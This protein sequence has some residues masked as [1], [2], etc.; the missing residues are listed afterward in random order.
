M[1]RQKSWR[2]ASAAHARTFRHSRTQE[3]TASEPIRKQSENHSNDSEALD[4]SNWDGT[5]NHYPSDWEM[6]D[7]D[8]DA[9]DELDSDLEELTGIELIS[10][11]AQAA[12]HEM[13]LLKEPTQETTGYKKIITVGQ[14]FGPKEWRK[15]ERK[16]GFGYTGNSERTRRR[17]EQKLRDK[18]VEDA[19]LRKR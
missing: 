13:D 15:A 17:N 2:K 5:V 18:E 11:L 3:P 6:T 9:A 14:T 19:K 12:Q 10:S 16:R 1:P 4:V 8:L 7:W